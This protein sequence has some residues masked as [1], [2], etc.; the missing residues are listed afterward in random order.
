[1]LH[2]GVLLYA[3]DCRDVLPSLPQNSA[4]VI[5]VDS[6]YWLRTPARDTV[7]DFHRRNNGQK[8]RIRE[9]WDEFYSVDDY[10]E[11]TEIWL[12]QT[13]RVLH[14]KGSM[15][16]FANQHNLGLI[17]YVLQRLGIEFVNQ[18]IWYKPN[19]M[20]NLS[21][22]R[23]Q[24]RHEVIIWAVKAPGYRFNYKAVKAYVYGDKRADVQMCDVW[25][26]PTVRRNESV[27]HPTQKPVALYERLLDM[28]GVRGG[29][30][31][32]PMAGSGT[33][34]IAAARWGMRAI[35]IEREVNYVE[36]IQQRWADFDAK[37]QLPAN[38]NDSD[39]KPD[40]EDGP[41]VTD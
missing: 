3:G 36:M 11:F 17:N 34:A 32:D 8:P 16:I 29:T 25:K 30:L 19:G 4:D 2:Q 24:C 15:F 26:L 21:G 35:L 5:F 20:P 14:T 31:L 7:V 27:G 33:A 40:A 9:A 6:P 18:I 38:D 37:R 39:R 41:D 12:A 13:M 22:R 1:M 10:L 23:L 28:C